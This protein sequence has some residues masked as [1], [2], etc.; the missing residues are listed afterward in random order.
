MSFK[1]KTH[2]NESAESVFADRKKDVLDRIAYLRG[3]P[4]KKTIS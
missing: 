4:M 3:L 1:I 2:T